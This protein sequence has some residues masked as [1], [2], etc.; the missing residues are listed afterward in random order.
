MTKNTNLLYV[1]VNFNTE[2]YLS[3]FKVFLESLTLF[4]NCSKFDFLIICDKVAHKDIKD[5]EE[6]R[7]F[8]KV[9]FMKVPVDKD[10]KHALLR[11]FDIAKFEDFMKYSKILYT[12][13]DMIIQ[14]DINK[15]FNMIELKPNK[16]YAT[17]EGE[18]DGEYWKLNAYKNSNIEKLKQE[19]VKSFNSGFY[20]FQPSEEMRQHFINVKKLGISYID[21]PYFYDQPLLN[22]Y[23]NINRLSITSKKL[24]SIYIMFPVETQYYPKA[25]I[26]H[27]AGLGRYMQKS[28][29][30][31]DYLELILKHKK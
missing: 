28:Q 8:K 27:I 12:D 18:I 31:K 21:K 6:L 23:F 19:N 9:Y 13:I 10:L 11:K 30:M 1:L 20:M 14:K 2:Y 15:V 22:Y 24:K 3:M 25:I 29:I 5:F 26:L 7:K 4:S 17:E 16:L